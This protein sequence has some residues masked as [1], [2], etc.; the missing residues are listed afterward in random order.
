MTAFIFDMDGTIVDTMRIH[1]EAWK[2]VSSGHSFSIDIGSF[3]K[4]TAGM[5]NREIFSLLGLPNG[6]DHE[7][8]TL[9]EHKE[10]VYRS[11]AHGNIKEIPGFLD[12][13]F[14]LK[15]RDLR[16]ALAT[17]AP[18]ANVG[19]VLGALGIASEFDAVVG[20]ED[21]TSGKPHPMTFLCAA[22][23]LNADPKE[24]VVFED[25]FPGFEAARRAGM[26]FVAIT[27]SHASSEISYGAYD[28]CLG[29][30]SDYRDDFLLRFR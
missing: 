19:L 8:R 13:F 3:V 28:G 6:T 4:Q 21:V 17:A 18:S 16:V 10:S 2:I 12:F 9:A 1:E 7:L 24:C 15:R 23:K 22:M 29:K 11:L 27:S 14:H 30:I 20:P 26:Q 5:T 25:S